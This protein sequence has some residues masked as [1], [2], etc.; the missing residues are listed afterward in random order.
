MQMYGGFECSVLVGNI[1]TPVEVFFFPEL[2]LKVVFSRIFVA[3][4][5][6]AIGGDTVDGSEIRRA[7]VEVGSVSQ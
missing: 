7:P 5:S 3:T 1:M 6:S 4:T 2:K